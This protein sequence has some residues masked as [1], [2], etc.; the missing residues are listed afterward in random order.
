MKNTANKRRKLNYIDVL[1]LILIIVA[2]IGVVWFII[3]PYTDQL[4]ATTYDIEYTVALNG[5]RV[6]FK[7]K[8]QVGDT[9][10][11]TVGLD[12]IG[13]VTDVVYT[14][15]KFVGTDSNG[16]SI[17]SDHPVLYDVMITVRAKAT[18]QSGVYSVNGYGITAG[19]TIPFR[20]P[21]FIGEGVCVSVREVTN[22]E[23]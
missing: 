22:E 17:T 21:D 2:V 12:D 6:E 23:I 11:E 7:D 8:V 14:A 10:V 16:H 19:K 5:V 13:S 9:L 15:S 18:M 20:V 4:F 1:L 3:S